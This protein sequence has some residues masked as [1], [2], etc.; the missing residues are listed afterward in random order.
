MKL[1]IKKEKELNFHFIIK[2]T[3]KFLHAGFHIL[4]IC[5]EEK[6]LK[7]WDAWDDCMYGKETYQY[8][9][10][11]KFCEIDLSNLPE[12]E[13]EQIVF[14]LDTESI[15]YGN[16]HKYLRKYEYIIAIGNKCSFQMYPG[17]QTINK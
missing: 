2:H 12:D 11:V 9:S 10:R 14:I 7:L 5:S 6:T 16:F 8:F 13:K 15:S 3:F 1:F 17:V 4:F